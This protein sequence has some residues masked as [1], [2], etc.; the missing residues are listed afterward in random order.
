M[1]LLSEG[2]E[3]SHT[4]SEIPHQLCFLCSPG[5]C[6]VDLKNKSGYTAVMLAS[7][8]QVDTDTDV[9]AVQQ[10]MELGDVNARAGQVSNHAV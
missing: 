9:E 5:V 3:F 4:L 7:L 8:Q 10:L 1:K 6:D 2:P